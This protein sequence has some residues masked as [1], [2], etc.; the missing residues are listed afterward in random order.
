MAPDG[1]AV[2]LTN[3]EAHYV[4]SIIGDRDEFVGGCLVQAYRAGEPCSP[5]AA[6]LAA[7]AARACVGS[8]IGPMIWTVPYQL[9]T[10][11]ARSERLRRAC[12]APADQ[13]RRQA[14]DSLRRAAPG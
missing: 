12:S 2:P 11:R 1:A 14:D 13:V 6:D 10:E 7:P 3:D 9:C 5:Y 8:A 4:L